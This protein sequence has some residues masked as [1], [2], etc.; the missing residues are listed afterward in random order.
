MNFLTV[1]KGFRIVKVKRDMRNSFV[2]FFYFEDTP[3]L[4]DAIG[5]FEQKNGTDDITERLRMISNGV[6]VGE[7]Y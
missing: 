5:E 3:E 1:E 2:V 4:K 7:K 6:W